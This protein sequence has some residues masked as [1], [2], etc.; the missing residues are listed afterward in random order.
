M[1]ILLVLELT[2]G[3]IYNRISPTGAC[4]PRD[5]LQSVS[6]RWGWWSGDDHEGW[7]YSNIL[8]GI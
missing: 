3:I 8:K 2:C 4:T 7:F 1:M 5:H 6:A